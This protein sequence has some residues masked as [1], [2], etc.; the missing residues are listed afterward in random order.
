MVTGP[1]IAM[2]VAMP[3]AALIV[4]TPVSDEDHCAITS[5][6]IGAWLKVPNAVNGKVP[7]GAVAFAV[8]G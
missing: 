1:P 2:H 3:V 4:T 5:S 7:V 6:V 8:P